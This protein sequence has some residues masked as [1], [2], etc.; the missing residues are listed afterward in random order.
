M[1]NKILGKFSHDLGIDLGTINT[2]I[3][4][5]DKGIVI[6]EPSVV[7]IN[8]RTEEVLTVGSKAEKMLGKTPPHIEVVEPL[9]NGII[10]DFEASE[11]MLKYFIDKINRESFALIP[12]PKVIVGV[13]LETTEVEKKAAEDAIMGVGAREVYLIE[14]IVASG[15]GAR[16]DVQSAEA[17][18]IIDIGGGSTEI[19]VLS[20]G[21]VVTSKSLPLAGNELNRSII[22]YARDEFNLLL[23]N[24]TAE[25]IKIKLGNAKEL[26]KTIEMKMQGRDLIS[27]LPKEVIVNDKQIKEAM[28]HTIQLIIENIKATLEITPPEL[29]ADIYKKGIMLTGGGALIRKLDELIAESIDIPVNIADDPL[30]CAVR[31]TGMALEN[32]DLLKDII[33]PGTQNEI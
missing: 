6:N 8:K 27:G 13:P 12:R 28:E 1:L 19:A 32:P 11:K 26:E 30:T 16:L 18:M 29:M 7:A 3:Y 17:N 33:I 20:L 4:V 23:G 22:Q 31:G 21:G 9:V 2:L 10:S 15:I 25:K 14:N 5:K 24:K